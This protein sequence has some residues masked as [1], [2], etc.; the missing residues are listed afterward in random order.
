[1]T[2][3]L[4]TSPTLWQARG[5][6]IEMPWSIFHDRAKNPWPAR[7][8]ESLA[9]IAF[10]EFRD[11]YRK[12]A[13]VVRVHA[14]AFDLDNGAVLAAIVAAVGDLLAIVHSTFS[15]TEEHPRWR[16]I[17]PLD[18][19]V[20]ADEHDR[21]WRWLAMRFERAGI[22]PDYAARDASRAWAV[23]AVPPSGYYVIRVLGGCCLAR[24]DEALAAIPAPSPLPAAPTRTTTRDSY[25]RR[26]VRAERYLSAMP[27]AISGSG[28][29]ATTFRAA[30]V[31]VRGFS[32][33]HEDAFQLL[34]RVHNPLCVPE[35]NERELRH[36][37]KQA[38]QRSNLPFGAI[39][40]RP[41]ERRI[42]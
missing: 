28:G 2:P 26:L 3:I 21:V 4:W 9:R 23:P 39:A 35:W 22:D 24:V 12:R 27:G 19:P 31:L 16:V 17:V 11:A 8:K 29:H 40:E 30:C 18:R 25:D 6:Q 10:V 13:N 34:A 15:A 36:K 37:I 42:G 41:I 14:I 5:R 32:L 38:F 7:S 33:D 1:M 20:T